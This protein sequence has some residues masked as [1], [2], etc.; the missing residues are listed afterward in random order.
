MAVA[1][2]PR[3]E[4]EPRPRTA[5]DILVDCAQFIADGGASA[6]DAGHLDEEL[7]AYL[8]NGRR[9][10]QDYED[11]QRTMA[12]MRQT[13]DRALADRGVVSARG[14]STMMPL[15]R[16]TLHVDQYL[17]TNRELAE[18]AAE[19]QAGHPRGPVWDR[20][21][22]LHES[23]RQGLAEEQQRRAQRGQAPAPAPAATATAQVSPQSERRPV[24]AHRA[25]EETSL[26]RRLAAFRAAHANTDP[27]AA[28][29]ANLP[30]LALDG[31]PLEYD[32]DA[33]SVLSP[34]E[35][36]ILRSIRTGGQ[37]P[38]GARGLRAMD[39]LQLGTYAAHPERVQEV[40][41]ASEILTAAQ[42]GQRPS[43]ED[44]RWIH[45]SGLLGSRRAR[46][47]E[48]EAG[49]PTRM[50]RAAI[51]R[52]TGR[53]ALQAQIAALEAH[54]AVQD[55]R[56]VEQHALMTQEHQQTR[57]VLEA[58]LARIGGVQPPEQAAPAV[59]EVVEV[60]EEVA[61]PAVPAPRRPRRVLR[62]VG[63]NGRAGAHATS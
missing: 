5:E 37:V 29:A 40:I 63:T 1:P 7:W 2:Q 45:G 9:L 28:T 55:K 60:P 17:L 57:A 49:I 44:L 27:E 36:D 48:H 10:P 4:E 50:T 38:R 16:R 24:G 39:R 15:L 11:A 3:Q 26:D 41:R 23:V 6:E 14:E 56:A 20:R 34:T 30:A 43:R 46:L 21:V 52:I 61:A 58:L 22:A 59:P 51:G 62:Q 18:A 47:A 25:R 8:Q 54:I 32:F 35:R 42:D 53:A 19:A 31:L 13:F 12:G 33:D